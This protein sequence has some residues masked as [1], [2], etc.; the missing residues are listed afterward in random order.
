MLEASFILFR[1]PPYHENFG[2]R[3]IKSPKLYFTEPGLA[4]HLLEIRSPD[5][6][7]RDDCPLL[8]LGE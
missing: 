2:K 6:V 1:L 7:A 3:Y 5:Q 8:W 4:A